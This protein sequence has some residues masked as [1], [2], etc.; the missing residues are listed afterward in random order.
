MSPLCN[1]MKNGSLNN[2]GY[3]FLEVNQV[4]DNL[5]VYL[6]TVYTKKGRTVV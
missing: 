4:T 1:I 3:M 2:G 6:S 5:P